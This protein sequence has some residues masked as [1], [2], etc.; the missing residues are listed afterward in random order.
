M[1]RRFSQIAL[2]CAM[3]FLPHVC[4]GSPEPDELGEKS[5]FRD[6]SRLLGKTLDAMCRD[7]RIGSDE[8]F[9]SFLTKNPSIPLMFPEDARKLLTTWQGTKRL[10]LAHSEFDISIRNKRLWMSFSG[11]IT[12][13]EDE[14]VLRERFDR[15]MK[16]LG[17]KL[18]KGREPLTRLSKR[19]GEPAGSLGHKCKIT[20]SEP[21]VRVYVRKIGST[22]QVVCS[23][24]EDT[25]G[26]SKWEGQTSFKWFVIHPYSGTDPTL[27][28]LI[29]T[30]PT[31]CKPDYV[32][33]SLCKSLATERVGAFQ[34]CRGQS[35]SIDF[36]QPGVYD[37]LVKAL[38][39]EGYEFSQEHLPNEYTGEVRKDWHR[40]SDRAKTSVVVDPQ[41]QT[42]CLNVRE[43]LHKGPTLPRPSREMPAIAKAPPEKRPVHSLDELEFA[44][45]QLAQTARRWEDHVKAFVDKSWNVRGYRDTRRRSTPWSPSY[46]AYWQ[47]SGA[48]YAHRPGYIPNKGPCRNFYIMVSGSDP[49]EGK[50]ELLSAVHLDSI[51]VPRDG[52]P[53]KVSITRSDSER[54]PAGHRFH[55]FLVVG[56]DKKVKCSFGHNNT[57]LSQDVMFLQ[58]PF[59]YTVSATVM[60][61]DKIE[62]AYAAHVPRKPAAMSGS[63]RFFAKLRKLYSSPE[64]LRD[65]LL[66]DLDVRREL[67]AE[68]IPKGK[69]ITATSF[70]NVATDRAPMEVFMDDPPSDEMRHEL[71][72]KFNAELDRREKEIRAEYT[73]IYAAM[74]KALSLNEIE[75]IL[76]VRLNK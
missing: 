1:N 50:E 12:V 56:R 51:W 27:A 73:A 69:G 66:A 15:A 71:L 48:D 46:D 28:E 74:V 32:S 40:S 53:A 45:P 57:P 59:Q 18:V 37:R 75:G 52:I 6:T 25:V 35:V 70:A 21:F 29:E 41:T 61:A 68:E 14:N 4:S 30:L 76:G 20:P 19:L 22:E 26:S 23:E 36:S 49:G 65:A 63:D 72:A 24:T 42:C 43:P 2:L 5:C 55:F 44:D 31:W 62:Y 67:A 58:K 33:D 39:A 47:S 34:N 54:A 10:N 17:Y 11:T 8:E 16:S 13:T 9:A 64:V 38:E 60:G 7:A 3:C